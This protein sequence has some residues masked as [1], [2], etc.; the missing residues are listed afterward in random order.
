MV[1]AGLEQITTPSP[2]VFLGVRSE[3]LFLQG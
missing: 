2:V 1:D 3:S